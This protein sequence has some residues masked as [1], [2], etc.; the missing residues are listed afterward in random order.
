MRQIAINEIEKGIEGKIRLVG[1]KT[2]IA[3]SMV[4]AKF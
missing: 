1:E 2:N 3:T 4:R